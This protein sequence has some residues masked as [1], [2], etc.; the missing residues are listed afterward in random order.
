MT[1]WNAIRFWPCCCLALAGPAT[2]LQTQTLVQGLTHPWSMAWL[3]NGD[4]L[5]TEREGQLR[6]IDRN[7]RLDPRPIEGLPKDIEVSGQGGLF[8]VV[9]HPDHARNGWI[10]FS[11]AQ[12]QAGGVSTALARATTGGGTPA[13]R[14]TAR[15]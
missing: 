6:R 7:F 12:R 1:L 11:Y 14:A 13:S 10:Y 2:A 4:M 8:D 5:V 15:P 3:P 9:L